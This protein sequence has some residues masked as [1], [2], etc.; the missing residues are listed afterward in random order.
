MSTEVLFD[1]I[2]WSR[3]EI[4]LQTNVSPTVTGNS[5]ITRKFQR[6]KK[7]PVKL[8]L[9]FDRE[10]LVT[11]ESLSL[12][13]STLVGKEFDRVK[14]GFKVPEST[15][16]DIAKWTGSDVL[17][18]GREDELKQ[19]LKGT[20]LNF[21]GGFDSLAAHYLLPPDHA[22]V[23]MDFGGRFGREA[24][25]FKEFDPIQVRTNLVETPLR[26][27]SWSF[28]GLG[29]LIA[30]HETRSK[31]CTFGSVIE[32]TGLERNTAHEK[33][34][35]FPPFAS[36]GM[37]NAPATQGLSEFGTAMIIAKFCPELLKKSLNSLASPGEEK[38]FRKWALAKTAFE[39]AGHP[40]HLP[41]ISRP[42]SPHFGFGD[43][44]VI[45]LTAM[46]IASFDHGDLARHLVRD[47]DNTII[48][49]AKAMNF[50]FMFK[51]DDRMYSSYPE[52]LRKHLNLALERAGISWY[53]QKD[54]N[55]ANE[56]RT[57]WKTK[58][59]KWERP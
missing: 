58:H 16:R 37:T 19:D 33:G 50:E 8:Y 25:F 51:A 38:L 4:V 17:T 21:S 47:L 52:E 7:T 29:S 59:Q 36:A 9:K 48:R 28:L 20:V 41:E 12:A 35:T 23:S 3:R 5:R 53:S 31:Y 46:T 27:N 32:S 45:D 11:G 13:L 43:R 14:F 24:K 42:S 1:P 10:I 26:K 2:K 44:F 6:L 56:F 18:D 49:D 55:D 40:I 57:Y 54:R 15:R 34:L 39:Y 22:L 30:M